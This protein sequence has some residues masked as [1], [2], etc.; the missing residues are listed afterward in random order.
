VTDK[1]IEKKLTF[2]AAKNPR[3]PEAGLLI[4]AADAIVRL[5]AEL[6]YEKARADLNDHSDELRDLRAQC[7]ELQGVNRES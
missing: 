7:A 1:E 3:A 6:R 2:W 4:A 5:R